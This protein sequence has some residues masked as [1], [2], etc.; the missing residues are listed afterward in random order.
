MLLRWQQDLELQ[1]KVA[2]SFNCSSDES[3][4]YWFQLLNNSALK[5]GLR[6]LES[7]IYTII[8]RNIL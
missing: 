4:F 6:V 8:Y 7:M 3:L 5:F 2:P 1:V